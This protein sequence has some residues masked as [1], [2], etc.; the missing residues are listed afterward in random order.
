M[1]ESVNHPIGVITSTQSNNEKLCDICKE[2]GKTINATL[3]CKSC[4]YFYCDNCDKIHTLNMLFKKHKRVPITNETSSTILL[5]EIHKETLDLFC[6]ECEEL[7]CY[8]CQFSTHQNHQIETLDK[9][10]EYYKKIEIIKAKK[11]IKIIQKQTIFLD[12]IKNTRKQIKQNQEQLLNHVDEEIQLLHKKIE[13]KRDVLKVWVQKNGQNKIEK[14]NEQ[15]TIETDNLKQLYKI[16]ED[17]IFINDEEKSLDPN[18][19]IVKLVS[20]KKGKEMISNLKNELVVQVSEPTTLVTMPIIDQLQELTFQDQIKIQNINVAI[21]NFSRINECFEIKI[22]II[23]DK[24]L[25]KKLINRKIKIK[26]II[27]KNEDN[28]N[29]KNK[30]KNKNKVGDILIKD[31][32]Y[33]KKDNLWIGEWVPQYTGNYQVNIYFN[34]QKVSNEL[35]VKVSKEAESWDPLKCGKS[36]QISNNDKIATHRGGF[37]GG[38]SYVVKG[39]KVYVTGIHYIPIKIRKVSAYGGCLL[40]G[41]IAAGSQGSLINNGFAYCV[42]C[43]QKHLRGSVSSFC[44]KCVI[45]DTINLILDM[46]KRELNVIKNN[47]E[48]IYLLTNSIPNSVELIA[49]FHFGGYSIELV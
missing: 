24:T 14:L 8:K 39:K 36:I 9:S 13:Q 7:V 15:L 3:Y 5:C 1:I 27:K 11:M 19:L 38:L 45:G 4:K 46:D 25:Y 35:M 23:N 20:I 6:R 26:S 29:N 34:E 30:N 28:E 2:D 16:N 10:L 41:V 32:Q 37:T 31:F 44:T 40:I 47:G 49:E 12:K 18:E 48:R 21:K 17:L 42:K 33:F 22:T 43:G